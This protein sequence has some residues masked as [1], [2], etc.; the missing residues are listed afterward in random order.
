M[1]GETARIPKSQRSLK[2]FF[3]LLSRKVP[4]PLAFGIVTFGHLP[5]IFKNLGVSEKVCTVEGLD[6]LGVALVA[7]II[8][9]II[10]SLVFC[11][12]TAR[13]EIVVRVTSR[14]L[15]VLH[16]PKGVKVSFLLG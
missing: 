3:A 7:L 8:I 15:R 2:A 1:S 12:P 9:I 4:T 10:A 5:Q 6:Y 14:M 13:R 16:H 11:G